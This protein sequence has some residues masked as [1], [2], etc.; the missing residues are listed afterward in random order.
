MMKYYRTITHQ[1]VAVI[2]FKVH[3]IVIRQS[4]SKQSTA[5]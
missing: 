2:E 4:S 3:I 1:K 5:Y